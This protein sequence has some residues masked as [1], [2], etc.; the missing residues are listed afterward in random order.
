[1]REFKSKKELDDFIA[2]KNRNEEIGIVTMKTLKKWDIEIDHRWPIEDFFYIKQKGNNFSL[3]VKRVNPE[4]L[5][6]QN[7]FTIKNE[8][9]KQ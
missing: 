6:W 5:I 4:Y 8:S 9:R 3:F 2:E 7:L 1:M